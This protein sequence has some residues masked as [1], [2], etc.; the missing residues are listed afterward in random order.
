MVTTSCA[1]EANAVVVIDEAASA[2]S[3]TDTLCDLLRDNQMASQKKRKKIAIRNFQK[4]HL[5][6]DLLYLGIY[7]PGP[8]I[9]TYRP[10]ILRGV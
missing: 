4:N 1:R 9:W 5:T 10:Q 2:Q 8:Q 7:A 3:L 6:I